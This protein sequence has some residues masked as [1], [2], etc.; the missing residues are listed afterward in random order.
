MLL[1]Y[2]CIVFQFFLVM[3]PLWCKPPESEAEELFLFK[4]F[5][6]G[7]H[8]CIHSDVSSVWTSPQTESCGVT[9]LCVYE[10]CSVFMWKQG[11]GT[12][13][14]K[15]TCV[16]SNPAMTLVGFRVLVTQVFQK[17][18]TTSLSP[19]LTDFWFPSS[20]SS[21]LPKIND[22]KKRTKKKA[23]HKDGPWKIRPESSG[24][25]WVLPGIKTHVGLL[26]I[27]AKWSGRNWLFF[28]IPV[29]SH[30]GKKTSNMQWELCTSLHSRRGNKSI[31]QQSGFAG[32]SGKQ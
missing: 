25:S 24:T 11:G 18:P 17:V 2:L 21:R 30:A 15:P 13:L 10:R 28:I 14:L 26:T 29:S 1:S 12:A 6:F 22:K 8:C 5:F 32:Y 27:R 20:Q 16:L 9:E 23:I 3:F 4:C 7:P 19:T 31:K